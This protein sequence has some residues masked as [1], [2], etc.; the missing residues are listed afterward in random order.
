MKNKN[1]SEKTRLFDKESLSFKKGHEN[2]NTKRWDQKIKWTKV[3]Q[4]DEQKFRHDDE[5]TELIDI[6]WKKMKAQENDI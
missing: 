2:E 4:T 6:T 3:K 5:T 1:L